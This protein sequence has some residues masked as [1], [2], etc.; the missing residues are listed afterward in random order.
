ME[1]YKMTFTA[2]DVQSLREQ[3]G[4]GMMDCKNALKSADGDMEKAVEYLREKGLAA[5]AKKAS[6]I[7]AEGMVYTDVCKKGVGVA[8]EVNSETDFVAKNSDFQEFVKNIASV[9]RIENPPDV[10]ALLLCR[11][12]DSDIA[13]ADMLRE[14]VLT[15]GENIQIRRFER[16]E[17][18][19]LNVSYIH[20][21][22]KIGVMVNLT[23][24][25][26]IKNDPKVFEL[27]HDLAMQ[28]AAMRP[29]WLVREDVPEETIAKE[30][31][32]LMAQVINEGK[33]QTVAEKIVGGR[34]NKFFEENCLVEQAYVKENKLSVLKHVEA[35]AKELGGAIQIKKF[36]RFEKGQGLAKRENNFADEVAQ[37]IK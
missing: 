2:K 13:V 20:M 5:A 27:G 19:G 3:T 8:V 6:R 11:Y 34:I 4:A 10:D 17:N 18:D 28:I 24:S 23:V 21:G 36:V 22:G 25:D 35:V 7:A 30:K 16:Y 26:Q 15:I 29:Q 37:M 33:P 9:I 32:I 31:E 12:P 14:K 1:V